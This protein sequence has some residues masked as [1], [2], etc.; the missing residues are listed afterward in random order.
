M[1]KN[2]LR[3][4]NIFKKLYEQNLILLGQ[5]QTQSDLGHSPGRSSTERI[6]RRRGRS[7][8]RTSLRGTSLKPNWL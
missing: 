6:L 4:I 8:V 1:L 3:H 2:K 5:E 7:K